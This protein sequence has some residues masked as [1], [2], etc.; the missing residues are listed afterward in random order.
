M[1]SEGQVSEAS[2]AIENDL[3]MRKEREYVMRGRGA[4]DNRRRGGS[5]FVFSGSEQVLSNL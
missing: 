5:Q 3:T 2:K 1:H 4:E